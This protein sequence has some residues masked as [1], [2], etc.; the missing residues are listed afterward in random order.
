MTQF[1]VTTACCDGVR[2]A[3]S[4]DYDVCSFHATGSGG[5]A[6]EVL[7]G[8]KAAAG[9]I[10]ITTTEVA[11]EVVGGVLTAGPERM[12]AIASSGLPCVMSLGA[13]DMVNFGAK[14]TVPP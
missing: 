3:L 9:V 14:E 13:L 11:D 2:E 7:V 4:A 8:S 5:K 12:D 1:G 6:M 10:D